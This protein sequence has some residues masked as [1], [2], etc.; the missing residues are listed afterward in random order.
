MLDIDDGPVMPA[1]SQPSK[2]YLEAKAKENA[3]HVAKVDAEM[4]KKR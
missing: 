2:K 1:P 3:E 4:E